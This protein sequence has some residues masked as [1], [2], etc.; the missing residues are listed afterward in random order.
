MVGRCTAHA[1]RVRLILSALTGTIRHTVVMDYNGTPP[2]DAFTQGCRD[3]IRSL[4]YETIL[5]C[6][7]YV[8]PMLFMI[9]PATIV[10]ERPVILIALHSLLGF[11]I[12]WTIHSMGHRLLIPL[13]NGL[14]T[15]HFTP[16]LCLPL[17]LNLRQFVWMLELLVAAGVF[18]GIVGKRCFVTDPITGMLLFTIG[19][20]LYFLPVYLTKLWIQRYYPALPLLGPTEE[21]INKSFR[22]LRSFLP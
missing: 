16:R 6:T 3:V 21:V 8:P 1:V 14:Y 5:A 7:V 20:L 4:T 17:K 10:A 18:S 2:T 22:G 9:G 19:L 12:S 11:G 15:I 13:P